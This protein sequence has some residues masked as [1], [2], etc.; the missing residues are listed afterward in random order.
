MTPTLRA[1]AVRKRRTIEVSDR[2]FAYLSDDPEYESREGHPM[3]MLDLVYPRARGTF[4]RTWQAVREEILTAWIREKPGTRPRAWWRLDAPR[5]AD[6]PWADSW[7]HGTFAEPR[8]R[9]G[10]TGTPIYECLAYKPQF[11]LGIP[12][13]FIDAA[14]LAYYVDNTGGLENG[15]HPGEPVEAF[16]P[17]DPPRYESQARYLWDRDLLE[18]AERKIVKKLGLLDDVEVVQGP[19]SG[20]AAS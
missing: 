11:E 12:D 8:R 13:S 1:T 2:A 15:D 20:G 9:L 7:C 5:W 16:D 18:P 6:D 17:K 14:A 3:E 4:E 19:Y 10:G